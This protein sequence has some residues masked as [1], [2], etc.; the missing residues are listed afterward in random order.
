VLQDSFS[1]GLY[2]RNLVELL[3]TEMREQPIHSFQRGFKILLSLFFTV[4]S[5]LAL[6]RFGQLR[7]AF[8]RR[9]RKCSLLL[10]SGSGFVGLSL[11]LGLRGPHRLPGAH[12]G[13]D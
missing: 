6:S 4:L 3:G 1:H 9:G 10:I 11:G 13:A 7:G 8:R 2:V 12:D 5:S